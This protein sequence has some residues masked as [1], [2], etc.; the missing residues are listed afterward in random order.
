LINNGTTTYYTIEAKKVSTTQMYVQQ[1]SY[2]K[3]DAGIVTD[4]NFA[5]LTVYIKQDN[6]YIEAVSYSA[7]TT[8][9]TK[10]TSWILTEVPR[11]ITA[12]NATAVKLLDPTETM[13]GGYPKYY[14]YLPIGTSGLPEY[15]GVN[16]NIANK[17]AY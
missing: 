16:N 17:Y 13:T 12:E 14:Y 7:S 1:I 8:Y 3:L 5:N 11:Q 6:D 4:D 2:Q 10:I 15:Y 9:Y